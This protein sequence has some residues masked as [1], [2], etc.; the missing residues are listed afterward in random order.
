MKAANYLIVFPALLIFFAGCDMRSSGHYIREAEKLSA[1]GK[2]RESNLLLDKAI[3]K[4]GQSLA[5]YIHRGTNKLRLED[6]RGAIADFQKALALDTSNMMA[7]FNSGNCYKRLGDYK[8]AIKYYS[9][10]LGDYSAETGDTV[11]VRMKMISE[12]DIESG[13]VYFQRGDAYYRTGRFRQAYSDMNT[14]LEKNHRVAD[15]YLYIG[16]IYLEN[17]QAAPACKYFSQSRHFGN[18]EAAQALKKYCQ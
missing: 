15:C 17:G 6:D 11:F 16:Y 8:S 7:L 4:N 5:A 10:A 3:A 1:K 12:F 14:A 2:Y 13:E 18:K 9:R